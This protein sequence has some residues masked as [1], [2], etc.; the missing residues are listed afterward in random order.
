MLHAS[1]NVRPIRRFQHGE[2]YKPSSTSF[3]LSVRF[4]AST[5]PYLDM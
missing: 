3:G 4:S 1:S 5:I 2:Q